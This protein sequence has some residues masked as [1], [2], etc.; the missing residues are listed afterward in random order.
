MS[1]VKV[2]VSQAQFEK[3]RRAVKA[4][5]SVTVRVHPGRNEGVVIPVIVN[6]SELKKLQKAQ[7]KGVGANL[8]LTPDDTMKMQGS[9]WWAPL[10]MGAKALG[11]KALTAAPGLAKGFAKHGGKALA[12]VGTTLGLSALIDKIF[13]RGF[14]P[15][16]GAMINFNSAEGKRLKAL[17]MKGGTVWSVPFESMPHFRGFDHVLTSKQM[18]DA[19]QAMLQK[20]PFVMK[21]SANQAKGGFL[22]NLLAQIASPVLGVVNSVGKLLGMGFQTHPGIPS[23][24]GFWTNPG[25]KN[26]GG[27]GFWTNP[28]QQNPGGAGVMLM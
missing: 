12:E 4:G 5:R 26:P 15:S 25:Q 14:V 10:L 11:T 1:E 6:N 27:E 24:N 8:L 19:M 18:N 22:G 2:R 21:L 9:G 28:G 20:K 17:A 13:G 3:V 7:R 23:G 16:G